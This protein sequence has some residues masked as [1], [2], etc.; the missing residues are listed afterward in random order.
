MLENMVFEKAVMKMQMLEDHD[1]FKNHKIRFRMIGLVE[2]NEDYGT[3]QYLYSPFGR[4]I[5]ET[6][7][8]I[9]EEESHTKFK[10]IRVKG[11][12]IS[13]NPKIKSTLKNKTEIDKMLRDLQNSMKIKD[14]STDRMHEFNTS[15]V[16]I[17]LGHKF[18]WKEPLDILTRTNSCKQQRMKE[19]LGCKLQ[20]RI[21]RRQIK[22]NWKD[23]KRDM[24]DESKIDSDESEELEEDTKDKILQC[25]IPSIIK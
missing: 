3:D 4:V 15:N 18:R 7:E 24:E 10:Q 19:A 8:K 5:H 16:S 14:K 11:M 21:L 9:N 17:Y 2:N 6:H 13:N 22:S 25:I 1:Y 20:C 12:F 23:N